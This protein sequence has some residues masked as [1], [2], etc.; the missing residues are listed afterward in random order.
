MTTLTET[1]QAETRT[2]T[3]TKA[4]RRGFPGLAC[5]ECGERDAVRVNLEDMGFCCSSCDHEF[6]VA[7]VRE[8]MASWARVLDWVEMAPA[9]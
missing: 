3:E 7:D 9:K 6:S 5:L 4:T 2:T 1:T 8:M